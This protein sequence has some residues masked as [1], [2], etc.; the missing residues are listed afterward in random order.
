MGKFSKLIGAAVGSIAGL[1]IGIGLLPAEYAT[2]E[3]ISTI[4][5][6][7]AMVATFFVPANT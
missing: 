1:L 7:L 3:I 6:V 2:P 5:G 4:T